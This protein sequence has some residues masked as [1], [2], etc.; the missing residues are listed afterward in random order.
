MCSKVIS[1]RVVKSNLE[2]I[3]QR[4]SSQRTSDV[5]SVGIMFQLSSFQL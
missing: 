4:L 1:Y 3:V 5:D 2:F